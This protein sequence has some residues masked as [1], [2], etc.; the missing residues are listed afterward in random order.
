MPSILI[1]SAYLAPAQAVGARRAERMAT[2][3]QARGWQVTVLTLRPEYTPPSDPS[4]EELQNIDVI[5]TH[6]L[7]PLAWGRLL[8]ERYRAAQGGSR[9]RV[10]SQGAS[11][12]QSG[13]S[14]L[15]GLREKVLFPDEFNGWL[16]FALQAVAARRF[17]VVLGTLPPF[18]VGVVARAVAERCRAKLVLDY[19]DP[20]GDLNQI[21]RLEP[22]LRDRHG[23]LEDRGLRQAALVVAVTPVLAEQLARRTTAPVVEIANAVDRVPEHLVC[24]PESTLAYAGSLAY[25]RSVAPLMAAMADLSSGGNDL[26]LVYAGPDGA[27]ARAAAGPHAAR[28]RDLGPVSGARAAALVEQARAGLV[29][30]SPDY[31]YAYPGKIFDILNASRPILLVGPARSAAAALVRRHNLGW[32]VADDD[33]AG[34]RQALSELAAG[35]SFTP[36]HLDELSTQT[37]MDRLDRELRNLL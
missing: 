20:W 13:R 14:R 32:A 22:V 18:T 36:V 24:G 1:V 19:R 4:R 2:H 6:A 17:D 26:Q 16:P 31:L 34:M 5:R 12:A 27:A 30:A 11:P 29:L 7:M 9:A 15:Q 33:D 10:A 8:R 37:T 35:R 25:G 21:T 3:L 23:R 28:L